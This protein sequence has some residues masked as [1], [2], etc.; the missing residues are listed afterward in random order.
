[1]DDLSGQVVKGY[2]LRELIGLGGFAAV[3]KAYQF[4]V[5]RE[6][7]IKIIL[8]KYANDPDFIRRFQAEA[9]LV[10]RLE[11]IHIVPLFDYWRELNNAYL[12]MRWLR[13][14]TLF[15][16]IQERGAWMLPDIAR[17]LDQ[18]TA[19]LSI[20]HRNDVIH[21]DLTPANILFDEEGNAYLTDFGIAKGVFT[22]KQGSGKAPLFGSP[23]YMAPEQIMRQPVS[24]QTDIYSLGIVLYQLLTG[25]VP[26]DSADITDVLSKQVHDPAPPLQLVRPN[27]PYTLN[28]VIAQATSKN[29]DNRYNDAP[30]LA[31]AFRMAIQHLH[32]QVVQA[33][34]PFLDA[35]Q[36]VATL[37]LEAQAFDIPTDVYTHE[38][39]V[40]TLPLRDDTSQ[41]LEVATLDFG[42]LMVPQNPYKGLRPFEEADATDFFGRTT[43]V[44][45]LLERLADPSPDGRFLA[46]V[47]PSGSGKSS[48][49][50][51]GVIPA[52]HKEDIP[53]A[54]KWFIA[55]ML[56]GASPFEEL[57]TALL[58]I[59][60][61]QVTES[62]LAELMRASEHGLAEAV[63]RVLPD[64]EDQLLLLIDQFEELFTQVEDE[65]QQRLF[66]NN[67]LN[68]VNDPASR[69]RVIITLRA[70]FYDRPLLFPAFGE[71]VRTRTEVVL[72]LSARELRE[73]IVGPAEKAGLTLEPGL[74]SVIVTDVIEQP[75]ALPLLQYALT[76]LFERRQDRVLTLAA[77]Q[78]SGG[79]RGALA[80][81][82]EELYESM[83]PDH[84]QAAR[85]LFLRMVNIEEGM[86]DTRRRVRWAE[87][88]AV[89]PERKPI[90]QA[91]LDMYGK[92]RLLTFDHDP[93]TREPTVEVAH[94]A[95]IREWERLRV[96]LE[97]NRADLIA[98]RR[99]A[100]ATADW[101]K[102]GRETSYLTSGA[103]LIQF[104]ALLGNEQLAL[105]ND[106]LAYIQASVAQRQRR[107]RIIRA[108]VAALVILTLIAGVA[109]LVALD[110]QNEAVE[111]QHLANE[112]ARVSRSQA[113]AASAL[114][115]SEQIDL[116]LLLSLEA[117]NAADT[118][119]ARN[120]LLTMLQSEPHLATFLHSHISPVRS[121]AFSPDGSLL[122]AGAIDGSV[123]LWD[124]A[125]RRTIGQP[126]VD[127]DHIA[128]V[129]AVAF[130]PDGSLLA[131]GLNDGT[132]QLWDVANGE[133]VGAPLAQ[134]S[135]GQ[136]VWDLAFHP[137][138]SLLASG[139]EGDED[140][141][142]TIILWDVAT[143]EA[144]DE[145]LSD[146][147]Q[148]YSLAFSPDGKILA[149]G[150]GDS[151]IY[152][153]DMAAD[154]PTILGTLEGHTNWVWSLAFSPDGSLLASGSFDNTIRLWDVVSR[155]AYGG[156]LTG[157]TDW[158][159]SVAFSD[160][161]LLLA[162]G[163]EAGIAWVWDTTSGRPAITAPLTGH[164]DAIW[165]VAFQPNSHV[166][167]T[168]AEDNQVILWN[169]D[170][171]YPL[172]RRLTGHSDYV[173]SVAVSPDG[174]LVASGSG[175]SQVPPEDQDRSVRLWDAHSG[176]EIAVLGEHDLQVTSLDFSPD[177]SLLASSGE[178]GT[179][180]LWDVAARE[181]V[182]ELFPAASVI[183]TLAFSPQGNILASGSDDGV[184]YLWDMAAD[185]PPIL[186]TLEGHTDWIQ[187]LAFS[188]DGRVLASGAFDKTII[189]WDVAA[190]QPIGDPMVGHT[191][192]VQSVAFSP[193]GNLLA[194]GSRDN[195]II[196]WDVATRQ[197]VRPPLEGHNYWVTSVIFSADG[198]LLASASR[199]TTI[200][201]WDV[202]LGRQLGLPLSGHGNWVTQA[203][204]SPDDRLLISGSR[205]KTLA[206][207]D[208]DLA[209]WKLHACQ[210]AN[211]N[212][213]QTEWEQYF[214]SED[215][216]YTETCP[217]GP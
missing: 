152:L 51:A 118:Y 91:V 72:P 59:A 31:A 44:D 176:E 192:V 99:L 130:S 92:F 67:I 203:V 150:C 111:A 201:L 112:R 133:P 29:P 79:V 6:V 77:Y 66:L 184:I 25:T 215:T 156:P 22:Y 182:G 27:L 39:D 69:L 33:R 13:G 37:D 137:D 205:D 86:E 32:P 147:E 140:Q 58:S 211:R 5:E 114:K 116:A 194:S 3:Y 157:H 212:L 149:S 1:M 138:G 109:A 141:K 24:P 57:Q 2:E 191:D 195:T 21:Q 68:A 127:A 50:R 35:A 181:S 124:M 188:P 71:L 102:S 146:A 62:E 73:A 173:T 96:W 186:G 139:S 193:D 17:L 183:R 204:F 159:R 18:I 197:P 167:A 161:G 41:Q 9:Q 126:L 121:V 93:Q 80:R 202:E 160:D 131:V 78:G 28:V 14:G 26:F 148:I 83:Q 8:P 180:I 178:E 129:N 119:E 64:D 166:L 87:I 103:R 49:V 115:N 144:V 46:V 113:L 4:A 98:Q 107:Q 155:S 11:H 128:R 163:D 42:M 216:S 154:D 52:L 104:E 162:S 45:R 15:D 7:A 145:L 136:P 196:L 76:E 12:V 174:S 61:G 63:R 95:L 123:I 208:V 43:F 200:R 125:E 179:I 94:E 175:V 168:G 38:V 55:R 10:A 210:V 48:V 169:L 190:R 30:S 101:L 206:M 82:A 217:L 134:H 23:A 88:M 165:S 143:R 54:N 158:V 177:G 20:A 122:A 19:A 142:G 53:G 106:E 36:D 90:L 172:V 187:S 100:S 209:D 34:Y 16:H 81:R 89:S 213:R 151:V 70:D 214:L 47:G 135:E 199:D 75:G 171:Q 105:T 56:P 198:S 40:S 185:D 110:R 170:S 117:F 60:V 120:S 65:A 132:I 85:Q 108:A 207:W 153:W 97:N 84:Q 164:L 189:L 74:A